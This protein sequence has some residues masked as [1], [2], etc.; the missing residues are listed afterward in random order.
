MNIGELKH[1]I[2]FE[3]NQ[4]ISDGQGGFDS[5]WVGVGFIQWNI[6]KKFLLQE[7]TGL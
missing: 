7:K 6:P 3:K 2:R 4:K 5:N 1:R